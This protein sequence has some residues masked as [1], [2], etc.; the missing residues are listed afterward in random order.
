M[1]TIVKCRSQSC[2]KV[3]S[4]NHPK[5]PFIGSERERETPLTSLHVSG[6]MQLVLG[7]NK[8]TLM[9]HWYLTLELESFH[10]DTSCVIF[11][12]VLVSHQ[13]TAALVK[14][15]CW[16]T[17]PHYFQSLYSTLSIVTVCCAVAM[18]TILDTLKEF[19]VTSIH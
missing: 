2:L 7:G 8:A 10:A 15:H 18:V 5:T 19:I 3:G 4:L 1:N 17:K 11:M 12:A 13:L 6:A 9:L 16:K 14:N